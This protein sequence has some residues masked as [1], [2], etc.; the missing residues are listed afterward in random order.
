MGKPQSTGN[1]VNA[2]A[3]DSS[4]NIGIGGAANASFKLQ[5]TG[6]T[7]LTGALSGTSATFSAGVVSQGAYTGF[8]YNSAGAYPAYNTY[9]GAIGTNFSNSN[10]ELDIWNTVGGGFVFRRQTGAS[11]QTALL[12][13]AS[14]GAATFYNDIIY[15][16]GGNQNAIITSGAANRGRMYLYDAGTAAIALQAGQDSYFLGGN[17]G[18]GTSSPSVR[19]DVGGA[20]NADSAGRF[21]KTS[22]GTLL[23]GGNR[24]TSNCPFIGSENNYDFA[25]ITNNAERMRITSDGAVLINSTSAVSGR[26]EVKSLQVTNEVYSKGAHSGFFWED[27]SNSANWYGWYSFTNTIFLFN[28]SANAAS[29]N[30]S[31]GIYTPLSDVNKKKDFE[32][33]KIGLNAILNLK[34]TLY[35]MKSDETNSSKELGFIAQEVKDF[36]P[37]AYV[38]NGEDENKFIGL[39]YNAIVAA[40]VKSVQ[41]QQ[42]QIEE[43]KELIKSK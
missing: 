41:E 29:I 32:A 23:L 19:L 22:E 8:Q 24:S 42:A 13:I 2:L 4:N 1:L 27:R 9:F 14:T 20:S 5:V 43:L 40:L 10:S 30:P 36:I 25:F 3:Q 39:N 37:Q 11:A 17:F 12:T 34:P 18:I 7:N 15:N 6:A 33:S 38:E 31:T 26:I 28:G 21:F 35:R 16:N